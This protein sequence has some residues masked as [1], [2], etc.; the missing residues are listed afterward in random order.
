MPTPGVV[1]HKLMEGRDES[2]AES[3]ATMAQAALLLATEP[4]DAVTGRV[5]YSQEVLK[6][7]GWV[8]GGAGI[9]IDSKG[10][11]YSQI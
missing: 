6:E 10:S 8:D 5:T 11:G 3:E 9:G 2:E 7:F 4:L 1:F